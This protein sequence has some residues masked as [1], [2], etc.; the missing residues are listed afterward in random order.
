MEATSSAFVALYCTD[1]DKNRCSFIS[2]MS[3]VYLLESLNVSVRCVRLGR[4][5]LR[6]ILLTLSHWADTIVQTADRRIY[7][8]SATL[9]VHTVNQSL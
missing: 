3:V 9:I 2:E 4:L 6:P 1:L 7:F 8:C 5:P